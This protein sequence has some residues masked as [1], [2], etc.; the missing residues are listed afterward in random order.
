MLKGSV[1]S[2]HPVTSYFDTLVERKQVTPHGT[3]TIAPKFEKQI[4]SISTTNSSTLR[5]NT[6]QFKSDSNYV[7]RDRSIAR[8]YA[9]RMVASGF[10][11]ADYPINASNNNIDVLYNGTNYTV[12]LTT[13]TL[14]TTQ[15]ALVTELQTELQTINAG[16]T[17][18]ASG[19]NKLQ[20]QHSTNDFT[21]LFG[22]GSNSL[23]CAAKVLGFP[24][25][26][27]ASTSHSLTSPNPIDLQGSP[28]IYMCAAG[29]SSPMITTDNVANIFA[30][31][32]MDQPY[33]YMCYNSFVAP[34]VIWKRQAESQRTLTF[35]F[36]HP[37][38][39]SYNFHGEPHSYECEIT[40]QT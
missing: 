29:I 1:S 3:G 11:N 33:G 17:V 19:T 37:N 26:D 6:Q 22:S 20:I 16:F 27:A 7:F 8:V 21:L 13:S 34:E 4:L 36:V 9:M 23:T 30:K 15:A 24:L 12:Q 14:I 39:T 25:A 5:S 31:I 28:Y 10:P 35:S 40:Y 32:Y 2:S 18:T 38:G